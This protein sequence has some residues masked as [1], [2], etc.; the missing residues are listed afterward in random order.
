MPEVD[1]KP[2]T[3]R[4]VINRHGEA[5][6]PETAF[7]EHGV[8]ASVIFVRGDGWAIGAP[9]EFEQVAFNLWPSNWREFRRWPAYKVQPISEYEPANQNTR[10]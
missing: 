2:M 1:I 8:C 5:V 4:V 3:D 7:H 6:R 9:L 10:R